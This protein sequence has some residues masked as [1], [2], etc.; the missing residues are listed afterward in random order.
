MIEMNCPGCGAQLNAADDAA[1]QMMACPQCGKPFTVS[2]PIYDAEAILEPV[3]SPNDME[4]LGAPAPTG[5][6]RRPCPM[7]GE[8]IVATAAKCRF[9]GEIFDPALR[10]AEALTRSGSRSPGDA[11]L[12]TG[13]WVVAIL[14]SGIGCIV[15]IVWMIQGKPKGKKMFAVSFL[16]NIGWGVLRAVIESA[17]K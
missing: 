4:G 5:E 3:S 2:E 13:E 9:C 8:M 15:G 16:A 17:K 14:C 7:C 6:E 1:G 10:K 11:D 12:S